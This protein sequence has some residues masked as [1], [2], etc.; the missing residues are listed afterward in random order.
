MVAFLYEWI[1]RALCRA[2]AADRQQA[3]EDALL[4][5]AIKPAAAEEKEIKDADKQ[6][7]LETPKIEV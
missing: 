5:E 1:G 3:D 2:A 6:K 4:V 7:S